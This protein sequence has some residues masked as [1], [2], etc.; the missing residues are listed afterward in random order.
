[1]VA[2]LLSRLNDNWQAVQDSDAVL[3]ELTDREQIVL[4][5]LSR[6]LGRVAIAARLNVSTNTVRTHLHNVMTKL[7]TS[8]QIAAAARGREIL[9]A[10]D[11]LVT[12]ASQV[13]QVRK[14]YAA[15]AGGHVD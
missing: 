14:L 8:S 11:P 7:G 9:A 5:L 6:G 3:S 15:H 4:R 13:S 1:M 10:A 2:P 12:A